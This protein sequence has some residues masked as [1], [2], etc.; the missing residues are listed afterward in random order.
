ME[1]LDLPARLECSLGRYVLTNI[2]ARW[3]RE[4][5]TKPRIDEKDR[6]TPMMRRFAYSSLFCLAVSALVT[7]AGLSAYGQNSDATLPANATSKTYGTGWDCD[8]GYREADGDCDSIRIPENAIATKTSYGRGWVCRWGYR[9][10]KE[11]CV[12]VEVPANAHLNASGVSWDCGRGFREVD[13]TCVD[14]L[15]PKNGFLTESNYGSGWECERGYRPV[16]GNC[17]PI[18]LPENAHLDYSGNDWEC[19]RP[20]E[21][22]GGECVLP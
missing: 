7:F 9:E 8:R 5:A 10:T 16:D 13:G 19:D 11:T 12:A 14:I 2:R 18:E 3:Q 6:S 20:F 17:M 15:V 21:N 22:R 1:S 4:P